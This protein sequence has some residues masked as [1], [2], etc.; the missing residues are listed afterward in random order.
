[1]ALW[2]RNNF[3]DRFVD[4]DSCPQ[5]RKKISSIFC[6]DFSN[7]LNNCIS[8]SPCLIWCCHLPTCQVAIFFKSTSF[9]VQ[10]SC[11]H[12]N[13]SSKLAL[14]SRLRTHHS[15]KSVNLNNSFVIL[16]PYSAFTI[17]SSTPTLRINLNEGTI[18]FCAVYTSLL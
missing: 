17:E 9:V 10:I 6:N 11:I 15:C 18:F 16:Y 2:P 14:E 5:S 1:V 13:V 7:D 12:R 3:L 8:K 4:T